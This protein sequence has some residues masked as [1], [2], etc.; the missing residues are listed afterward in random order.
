MAEPSADS[1]E[2]LSSGAPPSA[3]DP[4]DEDAETASLR[5]R[6]GSHMDLVRLIFKAWRMYGL[7]YAEW[8]KEW[9]SV[10]DDAVRNQRAL[11]F[12]RHAI[13]F[14]D[15][16]KD[17]SY[18]KH[19]SWYVFLTVWVVSRQIGQRGGDLWAYSTAPIESRGARMK[20]IARSCVSWR[21]PSLRDP[22]STTSEANKAIAKRPYK[23]C[24]M[25]Q[26]AAPAQCSSPGAEIWQLAP[27][28][29]G[30]GLSV[31]L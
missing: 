4:A 23:S 2:P 17:V 10:S 13:D 3:A 6:Y 28:L 26:C 27:H 31:S 25:L 11:D 21:G 1:A 18:K 12:L 8:M 22:D 24:V 29:S 16:M 15:V 9:P 7:L 20:R 14:S 19:K 30:G 5:E